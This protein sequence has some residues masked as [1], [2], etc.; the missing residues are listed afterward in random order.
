MRGGPNPGRA[1]DLSDSVEHHRQRDRSQGLEVRRHFDKLW[2]TGEQELEERPFTVPTPLSNM[3]RREPAALRNT[4][5][6]SL[7]DSLGKR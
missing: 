3:E 2:S 5:E 4:S 1:V 7:R 6:R